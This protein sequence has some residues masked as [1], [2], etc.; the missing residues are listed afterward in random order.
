MNESKASGC[1]AGYATIA[2][3]AVGMAWAAAKLFQGAG[4]SLKSWQ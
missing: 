3:V 2:V 1:H 4:E